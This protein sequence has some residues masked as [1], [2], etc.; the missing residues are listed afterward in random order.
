[1]KQSIFTFKQ[2]TITEI[3]PVLKFANILSMSLESGQPATESGDQTG[4]IPA[5]RL[6]RPDSIAG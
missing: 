5:I 1:M 4:R 3:L 6:E 2:S